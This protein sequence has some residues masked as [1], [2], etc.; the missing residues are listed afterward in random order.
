MFCVI[1]Y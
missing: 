1:T